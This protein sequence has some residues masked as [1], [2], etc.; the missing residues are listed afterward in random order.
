M[1]PIFKTAISILYEIVSLLC[2]D[3]LISIRIVL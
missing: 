1:R 3:H 2:S